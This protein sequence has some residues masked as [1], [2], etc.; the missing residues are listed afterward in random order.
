M[1]PAAFTFKLTVPRDLA[2]ADVVSDVVNHAVGYAGMN[3][4]AGA[5]F[6]AKAKAATAKEL[7]AGAT[8]HCLVVVAATGGELR[9]SV[10][11]QTIS[12]PI[13]V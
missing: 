1:T 3:E 8:S 4:E 2:L 12:Q 6:V 7:A 5:D 11:S 9:F 10:G 13:A